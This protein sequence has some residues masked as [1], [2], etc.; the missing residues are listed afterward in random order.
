MRLFLLL[1]VL[2]AV[3]LAA[4]SLA[5]GGLGAFGNAIVFSLAAGGLLFTTVN[6]TSAKRA[7]H[8]AK[9]QAA[10]EPAP[11]AASE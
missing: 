7:A 10:S 11:E 8:L 5:I 1:A 6:L 9:T 3:A 4:F 2:V